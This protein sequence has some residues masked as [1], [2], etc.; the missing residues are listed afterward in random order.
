M[1]KTLFGAAAGALGAMVLAMAVPSVAHATD[2]VVVISQPCQLVLNGSPCNFTGNIT[3]TATSLGN[4]DSAYNLQTNP[5]PDF[6]PS[7]LLDLSGAVFKDFENGDG[8]S[9]SG[10]VDADFLVEFFAV[11]AGN[12]FALYWISPSN[13][14]DWDTAAVGDKGYSHLV[15]F[16]NEDDNTPGGG[17]PEP[18]TWAMMI[19]GFGG[20]GSLMRRR[21][22]LP[23][24]A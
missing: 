3:L 10:H 1:M 20:V 18:A 19:M 11:K 9:Q 24:S 7:P 4:V 5:D 2:D 17:V 12:E 8:S 15:W 6:I 21:R 23:T 13:S 14:F 16:G 22:T